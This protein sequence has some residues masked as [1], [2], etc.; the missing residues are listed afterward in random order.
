MNKDMKNFKKLRVKFEISNA[1]NIIV[2]I[3][4]KEKQSEKEKRK[5]RDEV[6]PFFF[7]IISEA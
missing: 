4:R 7:L 2:K 3:S 6:K 1:Y 5:A